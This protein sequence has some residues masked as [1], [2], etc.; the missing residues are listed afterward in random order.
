MIVAATPTAQT[1]DAEGRAEAVLF[2]LARALRPLPD[3]LR[4]GLE[5]RAG[6]LLRWSDEGA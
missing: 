5:V 2:T 4:F 1:L 3:A 6:A